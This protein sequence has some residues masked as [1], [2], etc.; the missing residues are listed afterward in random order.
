MQKQPLAL[1]NGDNTGVTN[2]D[3]QLQIHN[4]TKKVEIEEA[5]TI[6]IGGEGKCIMEH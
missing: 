1:N 6:Q 3:K 5:K 4:V 2:N